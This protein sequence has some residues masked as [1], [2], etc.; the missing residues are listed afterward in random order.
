M[1]KLSQYITHYNWGDIGILEAEYQSVAF[2]DHMAFLVTLSVPGLENVISPKSRPLFKTS[3]EVIADSLFK[4]RLQTEMV[5]WQQV[6]ERGLA[7]S[8]WWEM[9]VKPGIRRLAINRSRE[10]NKLRRSKLNCLLL[11]QRYFTMELQSGV[12]NSLGQLKGV[13]REIVEWYEAESMKVVMQSRVD[14]VQQSVTMNSTAHTGT[15]R[16]QLF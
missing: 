15:V 10:V 16:N 3:P 5:G 8:P 9:I 14:D 2:S 13:H 7:V 1:Y 4:M 6:K 11:K 12:R